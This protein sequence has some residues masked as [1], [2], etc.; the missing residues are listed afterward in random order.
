MSTPNMT[1]LELVEMI[2]A[3]LRPMDFLGGPPPKDLVLLVGEPIARILGEG[4]IVREI[5]VHTPTGVATI[6]VRV[7]SVSESDSIV[8]ADRRYVT[9]DVG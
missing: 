9:P 2:R 1:R 7:S 3:L 6:P 8:V 4:E 5:T